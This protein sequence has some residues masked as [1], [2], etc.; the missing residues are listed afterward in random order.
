MTTLDQ[1]TPAKVDPLILT[2]PARAGQRVAALAVDVLVPVAIAAI[3]VLLFLVGATGA[4]WVVVLLTLALVAVT[5][6]TLGR[7][8][9]TLGRIAAGTRTVE[10]ATGAA[11]G[12]SVLA[13]LV[14]GRL[15]TY[16]IHRGRDPFAPALSPFEFPVQQPAVAAPA[17][18]TLTPVV[19]LDSG[20]RF[21]LDAPLVLGRN[22]T[23]PVDAPAEVY[24]WA[25]LSRTLSKSHARLEWDGRRVWVTDLASTNGTFVRT[26][27]AS[28]PLIAHQR[29]PLAAEAILELGDRIVTVRV[30]A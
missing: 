1:T 8:G 24:R 17:R 30:P 23:A 20:Q 16:D 15:G 7:S 29:T 21:T 25:D 26:G 11:A 14:A 18:S 19:E 12:A 10:R 28:Q 3:A 22:P 13:K 4:G 6:A 5:V 9:L 27:G 2:A